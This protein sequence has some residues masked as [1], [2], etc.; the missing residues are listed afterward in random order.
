MPRFRG[1]G[2]DARETP[3]EVAWDSSNGALYSLA[4]IRA[5]VAVWAD[6]WMGWE[7]LAYGWSLSNAGWRQLFC[8]DAEYRDDYEYQPVRL[9]GCDYF[10][11]RKPAWYAYYLIRNLVLIVLRTKAGWQGWLFLSNRLMREFAFTLLFRKQKL[12]RLRMLARGL[13]D[14]LRGRTGAMA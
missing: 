5:G 14:G 1:R 11:A 3:R 7:D 10:I 8:A 4:P 13:F 2:T 9:F 6:L 12:T